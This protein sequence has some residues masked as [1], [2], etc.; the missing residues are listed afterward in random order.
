MN[1]RRGGTWRRWA[2]GVTAVVAFATAGAGTASAQPYGGGGSGGG[3]GPGPSPYLNLLRGS[4]PAY[5][6]YYGLVRPEQQSRA[7]GNQLQQQQMQL[8]T[9][10]NSVVGLQQANR[11]GSDLQTGHAFG[12]QTQ[13]SYFMTTGAGAQGGGGGQGGGGQAMGGRI[14]GGGAGQAASFGRG[15][16]GGLGGGTTTGGRR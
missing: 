1:D 3:P 16:A 10:S 8:G 11:I 6:N 15:G 14:G 12:F 4:N 9:V 7:Q 13:R 5:L 2:V